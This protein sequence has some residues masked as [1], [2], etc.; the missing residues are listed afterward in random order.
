MIIIYLNH[1]HHYNNNNNFNPSSTYRSPSPHYRQYNRNNININR[2]GRQQQNHHQQ[3]QHHYR[4]NPNQ[5]RSVTTTNQNS[6]QPFIVMREETERQE[7]RNSNALN[8]PSRTLIKFYP[9]KLRTVEQYFRENEPPKEI[10]NEKDKLFNLANL[11]YQYRHFDEDSKKWK[12]YEHAASKR[13]EKGKSKEIEDV[14]MIDVEEI[15]IARPFPNRHSGVLNI[16]ISESENNTSNEHPNEKHRL[17]ELTSDTEEDEEK[18]KRKL[19]DTSLSPSIIDRSRA[20]TTAAAG[21][22]SL[23]KKKKEKSKK[24]KKT[25]ENDPRAPLGSPTLTIQQQSREPSQ[26]NNEKTRYTFESIEQETKN[27]LSCFPSTSETSRPHHHYHGRSHLPSTTTLFNTLF[28]THTTEYP[29]R[30][31]TPTSSDTK[32]EH[33]ENT[34]HCTTTISRR[35][36]RKNN[37]SG[38][39]QQ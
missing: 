39:D 35:R 19:R 25:T 38:S 10:E 4:R 17:S 22:T 8:I 27:V 16:T 6:T 12:I 11:C 33:T 37:R 14:I 26:N 20:T 15:P 31:T 34:D 30:T 24:K 32:T 21:T 13:K 28:N 5:I 23:K 36:S 7:K 1:R 29:S 2:F 3:Q 18:K 9:H